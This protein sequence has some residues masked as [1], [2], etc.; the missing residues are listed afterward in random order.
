[1]TQSRAEYENFIN[2]ANI[3]PLGYPRGYQKE[4]I[5]PSGPDETLVYRDRDGV[6]RTMTPEERETSVRIRRF[7]E[8]PRNLRGLIGDINLDSRGSPVS[9]ETRAYA[10]NDTKERLLQ[11]E[12]FNRAAEFLDRNSISERMNYAGRIDDAYAMRQLF[13]EA[14]EEYGVDPRGEVRDLAFES[15]TMD[16]NATENIPRQRNELIPIDRVRQTSVGLRP[17]IISQDLDILARNPEDSRVDLDT[18]AARAARFLSNQLRLNSREYYGQPIDLGSTTGDQRN[19]VIRSLVTRGPEGLTVGGVTPG[20]FAYQLSDLMSQANQQERDGIMDYLRSNRTLP[21]FLPSPTEQEDDFLEDDYDDPI[22]RASP[23]EV[24][25]AIRVDPINKQLLDYPNA[26]SQRIAGDALR[27]KYGN[28]MPDTYPKPT[29]MEIRE[30]KENLNDAGGDYT[31]ALDSNPLVEAKRVKAYYE[32]KGLLSKI[33]N[34]KSIDILSKFINKPYPSVSTR[35]AGVGGGSYDPASDL[36][37]DVVSRAAEKINVFAEA[38][39]VPDEFEPKIRELFI[40]QDTGKKYNVQ[41]N[42][43][44]RSIDIDDLNELN[45]NFVKMIADKPFA[46]LYDVDFQVNGSYYQDPN[47]PPEIKDKIT[48]FVRQQMM[49]G[50]PRGALV[51]N[52]PLENE[53]G[54]KPGPNKRAQAYQRAGF[55]AETVSKQFAYL[56]PDTGGTVPVQPFKTDPYLNR[57]V[58]DSYLRGYFAVDPITAPVRKNLTGAAGGAALSLLNEEVANAIKKDKYLKAA[59]LVGKDI[60][61]G[62]LAESA[63]KSAG[64]GLSKLAPQLAANVNPLVAGVASRITPPLVG[65]SLLS[66]GRPNSTLS[67]VLDKVAKSGLLRPQIGSFGVRRDPKTDIGKRVANEAGYFIDQVRQ[68]RVPY[69]P[70]RLF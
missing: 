41:L 47:T 29:P 21:D 7:T 37:D 24:N 70:G 3:Q 1:M 57:N 67:V 50:L 12:E 39:F 31:A 61:M 40:D 30:L 6:L 69:L 15:S 17:S 23:D 18:P 27:A 19:N 62:A 66:Q 55:G 53:G 26:T 11:D 54:R 42:R 10:V 14:P 32:K 36:P 60:G 63:I 64:R 5:E 46:G 9:R 33:Q 16:R 58:D 68:N 56:D 20:S 45:T 65:Y 13:G 52:Q 44:P 49:N 28:Y 38:P 51:Q 25:E 35:L 59:E 48:S 8:D 4:I 22:R 43:T 34:A 2:E